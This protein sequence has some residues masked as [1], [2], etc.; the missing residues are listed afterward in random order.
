MLNDQT[1]WEITAANAGSW[2]FRLQ[3]D[4]HAL[5]VKRDSRFGW[6]LNSTNAEF[7]YYPCLFCH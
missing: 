6:T 3:P 4:V 7:A 1:R 2:L 5:V